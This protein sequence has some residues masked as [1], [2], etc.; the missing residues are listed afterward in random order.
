M[1][2]ALLDFAVMKLS[3]SCHY[4]PLTLACPM[5]Q[6]PIMDAGWGVGKNCYPDRVYAMMLNNQ[7]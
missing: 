4:K 3:S 5:R 7:P 2:D 6:V 1:V